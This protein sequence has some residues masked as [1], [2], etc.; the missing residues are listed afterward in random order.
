MFLGFIGFIFASLL[1]IS[2]S[3]L[4]FTCSEIGLGL[5]NITHLE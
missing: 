5:T 2:I 1:G 4:Y 3:T